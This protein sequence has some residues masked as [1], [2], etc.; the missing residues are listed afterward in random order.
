MTRLYTVENYLSKFVS[1]GSDK[2]EQK[3]LFGEFE[4]IGDLSLENGD[5]VLKLEI[6]YYSDEY[7]LLL[8]DQLCTAQKIL[9]CELRI[10]IMAR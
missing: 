6:P 9:G 4:L 10:K 3:T 5:T 8:S 7:H 2:G 1:F